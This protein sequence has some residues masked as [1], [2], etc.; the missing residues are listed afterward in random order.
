MESSA[1]SVA[2]VEVPAYSCHRQ[3]IP[4]KETSFLW[5]Y[6][7]LHPHDGSL[8]KAQAERGRR[9]TRFKGALPSRVS[10]AEKASR[11]G[12]TLG[13]VFRCT[14]FFAS[15]S[16]TS[17]RP[18]CWANHESVLKLL[19]PFNRNVAQWKGLAKKIGPP[20][21][22]HQ[23]IAFTSPESILPSHK[24]CNRGKRISV[25]WSQAY[26]LSGVHAFHRTANNTVARCT[27]PSS[28]YSRAIKLGSSLWTHRKKK[29]CP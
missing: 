7:R 16:L 28:L 1:N 25:V 3:L 29:T 14:L 4:I 18:S 21:L 15:E 9:N 23:L 11:S 20:H 12:C 5:L 24:A 26:K 13:W 19:D 27:T 6:K 2:F 8:V 22:R 17:I 10:P